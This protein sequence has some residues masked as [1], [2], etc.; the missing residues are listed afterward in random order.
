MYEADELDTLIPLQAVPEFD[1]GAPLPIV[2]AD[3]YALLLAYYL[4]SS[5]SQI[6][7]GEYSRQPALLKFQLPYAHFM[8]PCHTLGSHPLLK[9][10]L[11]DLAAFEVQNSSWIRAVERMESRCPNH[12]ADRFMDGKRHFIF[13]FRDS[14][15]ECIATGFQ[16]HLHV[17]I[18]LTAFELVEEMLS[19][20]NS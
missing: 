11:E 4:P 5:Q 18:P 15:F 13:V 20:D 17:G 3:D 2:V 10:S 16:V 1:I 7:E 9:R 14:T 8:L 19:E 6:D 12:N